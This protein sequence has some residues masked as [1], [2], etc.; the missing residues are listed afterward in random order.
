MKTTIIR[1]TMPLAAGTRVGPYEIVG[2]IG[3]GGMGEVYRARDTRLGRDVA[4]KVLPEAF[5]SDA[6]RMGRFE[7]EAKVLASLNHPNIASIYGFEESSGVRALVM[8]LVEGQTLAE[9][10]S[11]GIAGQGSGTAGAGLKAGATQARGRARLA[12]DEALVIARQIAE[13][14]E[15]AHERGIVHR[16]LKPANVKITP[17]GVVKILDFGLAKA[18][19]GEAAAGNPSSSPTMSRLATQ[20]GILLGT[21]SYMAPEQAKGKA[22][23]RRAD[24]WAFGC[25]LFEM[26]T[27]RHAFDGETVTDVLA[28][29]VMKEPDW[30]LLPGSTSPAI[31]KLIIRCLKKDAKQRLQAIGEARIAIEEAMSGADAEAPEFGRAPSEA[32]AGRGPRWRR[33]LPCA[34][35]LAVGIALGG[36]MAISLWRAAPVAPAVISQVLPPKGEGFAFDGQTA[37]PPVLSPDGRKLAFAAISSNGKQQLWVRPLDSATAEPLAG[38]EGATYP[39]WSPDSRNL[40][41]FVNGKLERIDTSGG[42]P[43]ALCDAPNGRG[44]TWGTDGTILF[45]P[46][47]TRVI[48]SV[49]STGGTPKLVEKMGP[50]LGGL[51]TARWPQ[52]LPDGKHFLFY[53]FSDVGTQSGTYA[54]ALDGGVPK[55]IVAGKSNAVYAPPGYLLF[56]RQGTLMAQRF[57][58]SKLR[59]IGEATSVAEEVL[60]NFIV[61]RSIFTASDTGVLAY[62]TGGVGT[63]GFQ[64]TWVDR[65][66]KALAKVGAPGEYYTPRISPDGKKLAVTIRDASGDNLWVVDLARDIKTRLT[67]SNVDLSGAW[68]PDGK[69]IAFESGRGKLIH[70]YTKAADGTGRTIPLVRG[71]A[72]EYDPVWSADGRYI[73]YERSEPASPTQTQIWAVPMFGER[74]PFPVVQ[75]RFSVDQPALSADGKWLAYVSM[76]SGSPE[77]YVARFGL[78]GAIGRWQVSAG[79]GNWPEWR[80]DGKELFYFSGDDKIMS[81]EISVRG[82]DILIGKVQ[83]LFQANYSG[84]PGWVYDV[85]PDGK[86][87]LLITQGSEQA[88]RPLTLVV[89]WPALLEAQP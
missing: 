86:K 6:E 48:Y 25:V 82:S 17:D 16:D 20:A 8:E 88:A 80:R 36:A 30:S 78:G 27:G 61:F 55:L 87:F 72:N 66:G 32:P 52:F 2:A 63:G 35:F 15:Y 64:L 26:L 74:K 79:G 37:G 83:P 69:T 59:L 28:A 46:D 22:I 71:D 1:V 29:I 41:F 84:G 23:D 81:A 33:A 70:L 77:V 89:N 19:E 62:E 45:T 31:R 53:H 68:S 5:A 76:E 11:R 7:R 9:Q 38:T 3:A 60:Q 49:P 47:I 44:G 43:L 4:L 56:I 21:A 65:S 73:L 12:L 50:Q 34:L 58:A 75:S 67:F 13:G 85:S 18:L 10:I 24:I 42:S 57:D 14:L 51:G 40:G 39:F 54:I